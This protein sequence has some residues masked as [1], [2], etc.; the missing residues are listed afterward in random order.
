MRVTTIFSRI[1]LIISSNS[2]ASVLPEPSGSFWARSSS[3]VVAPGPSRNCLTSF[4]PKL[5][6]SWPVATGGDSHTTSTM[7]ASSPSGVDAVKIRPSSVGLSARFSLTL[8]PSRLRISLAFSSSPFGFHQG[9]FAKHH[10][11][12]GFVTQCFDCGRADFGHGCVSPYR[13]RNRDSHGITP[14]FI[15]FGGRIRGPRAADRYEIEGI[16]RGSSFAGASGSSGN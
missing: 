2:S 10:R 6:M 11:Q 14:G 4:S 7:T 13:H 9:L 1:L 8:S 3:G 15:T 5:A 12:V 16:G